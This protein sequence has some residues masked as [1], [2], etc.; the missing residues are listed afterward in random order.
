[1]NIPGQIDV[2]GVEAKCPCGAN[3]VAGET[4]GHPVVMHS[5]PQCADFM[6]RDPIAYL[7][8][9]NARLGSS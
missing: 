1:M 5:M 3:V 6:N 7:R 8:W 4:D 2:D 9:L